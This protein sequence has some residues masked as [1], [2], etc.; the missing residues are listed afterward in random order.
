MGYMKELDIADQNKRLDEALA[1]VKDCAMCHTLAYMTIE[2]GGAWD[3][4]EVV[5][6]VCGR[7]IEDGPETIINKLGGNN[8]SLLE[9]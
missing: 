8:L 3:I 9:E 1:Q 5:C 7:G 2:N 6:K 4:N